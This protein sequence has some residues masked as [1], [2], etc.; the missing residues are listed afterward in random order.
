M[1]SQDAITCRGP[2]AAAASTPLIQ[3]AATDADED[4]DTSVGHVAPIRWCGHGAT[5]AKGLK[6]RRVKGGGTMA[7]KSASREARGMASLADS[8]RAG[9]IVWRPSLEECDGGAG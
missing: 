4:R 7:G 9:A 2:A 1:G 6:S 8:D 3:I 5:E